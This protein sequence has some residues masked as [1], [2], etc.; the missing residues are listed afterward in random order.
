MS[1]LKNINELLNACITLRSL[2][3]KIRGSGRGTIV[4][5]SEEH[6]AL[7]QALAAMDA[8]LEGGYR[9]SKKLSG[10]SR[11]KL[12][13]RKNSVAVNAMRDRQRARSYK[14]IE[15]YLKVVNDARDKV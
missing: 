7:Q 11:T 9:K 4:I 5:G 1:T 13:L 2:N 8:S 3:T 10:G 15:A 14:L 12:V 6:V